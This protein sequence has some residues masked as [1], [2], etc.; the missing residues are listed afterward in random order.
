[1]SNPAKKASV[2]RPY[3]GVSAEDR[4][5]DRRARFLAAGLELIGT[6]GYRAMTLRM[7]CQKAG[8]NDR[9]FYESFDNLE[10]FLSKLYT[11][12]MDV[13]HEKI[14]SVAL[15]ENCPLSDRMK[16][17]ISVYFEFMRNPYVARLAFTE[18]LGVSAKID[19][20]YNAN[21]RRF[22][23]MLISFLRMEFPSVKIDDQS[24]QALGAGLTGACTMMATHWMLEGYRVPVGVMVESCC[25]IFI[26]TLHK[27][28]VK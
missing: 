26:G 2:K 3:A 12:H 8:L 6:L 16:T 17:G 7:L 11:A 23:Q 14:V 15:A 27:L 22:G 24:E 21:T 9:Y 20:L 28:I 18:I 13:L 19:N 10:D 1:M 25:D 5:A 4:Q